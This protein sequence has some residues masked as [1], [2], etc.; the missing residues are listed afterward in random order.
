MDHEIIF[1]VVKYLR[2]WRIVRAGV[3]RRFEIS[4]LN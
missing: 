3:D 4:D 2:S 1:V